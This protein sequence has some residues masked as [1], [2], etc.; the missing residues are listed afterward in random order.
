MDCRG[1][2]RLLCRPVTTTG[3]SSP[4]GRP[5]LI[6]NPHSVPTPSRRHPLPATA[7]ADANSGGEDWEVMPEVMEA[8]EVSKVVEV[9]KVREVV[10]WKE[11]ATDASPSASHAKVVWSAEAMDAA[12]AVHAAHTVHAAH[13]VHAAAHAA[14]RAG[15]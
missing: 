10:S 14:H 4:M 1:I 13:A 8:M 5:S 9:I 6:A 7:E 3:S 2:G 15:G 11:R 12:K